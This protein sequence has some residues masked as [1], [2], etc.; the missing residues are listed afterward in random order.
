MTNTCQKPTKN[1]IE[2]SGQIHTT[3]NAQKK[4]LTDSCQNE[5]AQAPSDQYHRQRGSIVRHRTLRTGAMIQDP[6]HLQG[7]LHHLRYP[8]NCL[9][10]HQFRTQKH[11]K[12]F[13]LAGQDGD[14][15]TILIATQYCRLI[16]LRTD[17]QLL[18]SLNNSTARNVDT[19][20]R[21]LRYPQRNLLFN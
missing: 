15:M 10:T 2:N 1:D 21:T 13:D 17:R 19:D 6:D 5:A 16:Y 8:G 12:D 18:G 4:I 7:H 14:L 11:T 20:T 9:P 3:K